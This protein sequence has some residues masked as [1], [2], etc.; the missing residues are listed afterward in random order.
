LPAMGMGLQERPRTK[1]R[2]RARVGFRELVGAEIELLEPSLRLRMSKQQWKGGDRTADKAAVKARGLWA[3]HSDPDL[4]RRRV[5]PSS[6]LALM[7]G[8][9]RPHERQGMPAISVNPRLT[10]GNSEHDGGRAQSRAA[11]A[12]AGAVARSQGA[13]LLARCVTGRTALSPAATRPRFKNGRPARAATENG[14]V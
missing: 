1:P 3:A 8:G 11:Q 13:R 12:L 5:R 6:R 14:L 10:R 9:A 4:G 7:H 2:R